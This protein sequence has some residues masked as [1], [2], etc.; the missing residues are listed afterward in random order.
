MDWR[1][2]IPDDHFSDKVENMKAIIV[3]RSNRQPTSCEFSV[4][5][6]DLY[7]DSDMTVD[8]YIYFLVQCK[9]QVQDYDTQ[10]LRFEL[11]KV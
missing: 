10:V 1:T 5:C 6:D 3:P 11:Y 7:R 9:K 8:E 4:F 2:N